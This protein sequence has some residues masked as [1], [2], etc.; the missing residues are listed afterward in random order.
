MWRPGQEV[1]VAPTKRG[2]QV[3]RGEV[4]GPSFVFSGVQ[5]QCPW[6]RLWRSPRKLSNF[7][8]FDCLWRDFIITCFFFFVYF[9]YFKRH[10]S[11][12]NVAPRARA[13]SCPPLTTPLNFKLN[14]IN[15][16]IPGFC[17]HFT[18]NPI[19]ISDKTLTIIMSIPLTFP[20]LFYDSILTIIMSIP[21]AFPVLKHLPKLL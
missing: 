1:K 12:P 3:I 19:F 20:L 13:P 5:G 17:Q 16:C 18:G 9:L 6:R 8:I 14:L 4:H 2:T 7:S 10:F 11:A 15:W 21:P